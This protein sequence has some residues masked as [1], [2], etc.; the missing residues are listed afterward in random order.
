MAPGSKRSQPPPSHAPAAP[1]A[2]LWLA[3]FAGTTWA[4]LLLAE[5]LPHRG[6]PPNAP[7]VVAAPI[8]EHP[9]ARRA[10]IPGVS[11]TWIGSMPP[12]GRRIPTESL[13]WQGV[14]AL[15]Q[16]KAWA[17]VTPANAAAERMASPAHP[18]PSTP[19]SGALLLG[20]P[21]GLE[22]LQ[23]RAMVPAARLEQALR[24][25]SPDR[26]DG[27][28]PH[29]RPAMRALL[30]GPEQVLPAEV[31]RLPAPHL[32]TPEEYPLVV[33]ADGLAET[34]V[35]PPPRSKETME[36]WAQHLTASPAGSA[37]PILVV[38]EPLDPDPAARESQHSAV[39]TSSEEQKAPYK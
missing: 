20:G 39:P 1:W 35:T 27:V 3:A 16:P 21:L 23:E 15:R 4:P 12:E 8:P 28:P 18:S 36:R 26:L 22:S 31:V 11:K 14:D 38:L 29:W 7:P 37:R 13:P 34:T 9:P 17:A 5:K 10:P 32:K 19:I 2:L 33:K 24:A 25:R 6:M 30:H